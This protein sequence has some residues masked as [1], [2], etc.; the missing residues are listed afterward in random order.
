[1]VGQRKWFPFEVQGID[2]V[3]DGLVEDLCVGEGLMGEIMGFEVAPDGFPLCQ[4][5][6]PLLYFSL[7][8]RWAD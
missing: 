4:G 6:C 5:S 8:F 2:G 1:M 7:I 3:V